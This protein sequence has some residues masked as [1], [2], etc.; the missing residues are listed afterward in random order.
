MKD[1]NN[2]MPAF[3][4]HPIMSENMSSG[5]RTSYHFDYVGMTLRDYAAI[6]MPMEEGD[7]TKF[8]EITLGRAAPQRP[9]ERLAYWFEAEAKMRYMKADAMLKARLA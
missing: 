9:S 7:V 3:P 1:K 5:E 6:N 4:Q 2:D 8:A